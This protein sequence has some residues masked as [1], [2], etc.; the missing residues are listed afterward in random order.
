MPSPDNHIGKDGPSVNCRGE[1]ARWRAREFCREFFSRYNEEH[2]HGGI[3]LMT[4][5]SV[6]YGRAPELHEER[7]RVLDA[8]CALMPERF[9]TR[10]PR[11]PKLPSAAWIN[12]PATEEVAH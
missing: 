1:P 10:P 9:V 2:R 11:P 4:P 12:K 6:H 5:A 3:G 8:A 7:A